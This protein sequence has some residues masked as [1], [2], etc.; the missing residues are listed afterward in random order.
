[1]KQ[2]LAIWIAIAKA[3]HPVTAA[4]VRIRVPSKTIAQSLGHMVAQKYVKR[5]NV[6]GKAKY[7]ALEAPARL[8]LE[9]VMEIAKA[10]Q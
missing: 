3:T 9:H 1:M 4:Y 5:V 10:R 2:S 6:E 7:V 8:T